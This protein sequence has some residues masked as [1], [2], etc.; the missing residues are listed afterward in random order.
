M[1]PMQKIDAW[2]NAFARYVAALAKFD[3]AY[4]QPKAEWNARRTLRAARDNL[5]RVDAQVSA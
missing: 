5:A 4:G 3:A 1:T 2:E